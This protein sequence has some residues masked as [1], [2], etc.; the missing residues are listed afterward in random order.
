MIPTYE[1]EAGENIVSA[2]QRVQHDMK[3]RCRMT[4]NLIFNDITLRV[5]IDSNPSD[6]AEIYSLKCELQRYGR[7]NK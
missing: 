3:W 6:I 4:S 2:V 7:F 1:A 5:S